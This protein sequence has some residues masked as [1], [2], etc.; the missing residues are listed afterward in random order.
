MSHTPN[1][2]AVEELKHLLL[3]RTLFS[4]KPYHRIPVFD[5]LCPPQGGY[6]NHDE[7]GHRTPL[8]VRSARKELA[9]CGL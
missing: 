1:M 9:D 4:A 8:S 5:E 7:V 2:P 3:Q 6:K